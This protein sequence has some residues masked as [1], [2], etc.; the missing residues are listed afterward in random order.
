MA[1]TKYPRTHVDLLRGRHTAVLTTVTRNGYPHNSPV[2][3]LLD[4]DDRI[5]ISVGG[6]WGTGHGVHRDAKG[7]I[8]ILDPY[9]AARYI[10]IHADLEVVP[11]PDLSFERRVGTKYGIDDLP[12]SRRGAP[13]RMIL[14]ANPVSVSAHGR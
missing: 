13:G 9:N 10:E 5:K 1:K 14:V 6:D 11:D 4:D 8:L 3:F 7:N 2:L 12:A